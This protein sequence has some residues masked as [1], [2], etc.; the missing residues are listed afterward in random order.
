MGRTPPLRNS[1][2]PPA[3]TPPPPPT[4]SPSCASTPPL[5]AP[6]GGPWPSTPRPSPCAPTCSSATAPTILRFAGPTPQPPP[7]LAGGARGGAHAPQLRDHQL[8][9]HPQRGRVPRPR[10]GRRRGRH[11]RA[12]RRPLRAQGA[13][14]SSSSIAS[15]AVPTAVT[16][17]A[18]VTPPSSM[19]R[20]VFRDRLHRW[21]PSLLRR[22]PSSRPARRRRPSPPKPPAWKPPAGEGEASWDIPELVAHIARSRGFF[23]GVYHDEGWIMPPRPRHRLP[24]ALGGRPRRERRRPPDPPPGHPRR[25]APA[26]RP[27]HRGAMPPSRAGASS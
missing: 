6:T 5:S 18:C 15:C 23:V 22:R 14:Q 2:P 7:R 27:P 4:P 13:S 3:W 9:P 12:L 1:R 20:P 26:P 21:L 19:P 17:S 10:P 24:R 11:G 8:H 16:S 25:V